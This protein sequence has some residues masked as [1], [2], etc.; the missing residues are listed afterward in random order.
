M[1]TLKKAIDYPIEQQLQILRWRNDERIAQY[2]LIDN[3]DEDVHLNWINN[4]KNINNPNLTFFI[5][6]KEMLIGCAYFRDIDHKNKTAEWGIFLDPDNTQIPNGAGAAAE[7][8]IHEYAFNTL[9]LFKLNIRVLDNNPAVIKMHKKFGYVEEGILR[10]NILKNNKRYDLYLLGLF[11]SEW[12]DTK[13]KFN[14]L[15]N[16]LI[17]F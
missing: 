1:I 3:I 11:Q 12:L 7:Y 17:E 8:L 13:N 15:L 16:K 10:E 4:Q 5:L 14:K 9:D 6:Y 2:F